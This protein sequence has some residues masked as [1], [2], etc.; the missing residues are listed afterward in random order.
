MCLHVSASARVCLCVRVSE[1]TRVCMC[2]CAE[3]RWGRPWGGHGEQLGQEAP[4][5]VGVYALDP[6]RP[7]GVFGSSA[8]PMGAQ[9]GPPTGGT[10][11]V[12]RR[13]ARRGPSEPGPAATSA[14]PLLVPRP[15]GV[16]PAQAG[17]PGTRCGGR[18]ARTPPLSRQ[19]GLVLVSFRNSQTPCPSWSR[20]SSA[21]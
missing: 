15:W 5:A 13:G 10:V 4:E 9:A 16:G 6:A 7:P 2:T 14:H 20:R 19:T 21:S 8:P 11:A 17:A 12:L 3:T 18:E 1:R